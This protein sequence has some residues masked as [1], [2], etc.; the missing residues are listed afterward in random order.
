M[1]INAPENNVYNEDI[2][3]NED[4]EFLAPLFQSDA[5]FAAGGNQ[6]ME[7]I[8]PISKPLDIM[9]SEVLSLTRT[10]N[11]S[12]AKY[13]N[14]ENGEGGEGPKN[15]SGDIPPPQFSDMMWVELEKELDSSEVEE[16]SE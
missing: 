16:Y 1:D 2:V 10:S 3:F 12:V 4:F 13:S 9:D 6:V 11:D 8:S 5:S 14:S 7:N 15:C